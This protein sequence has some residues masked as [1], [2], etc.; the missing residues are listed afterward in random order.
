MSYLKEPD[1]EVIRLI[2]KEAL[3]AYMTDLV[4]RP[5]A[6]I[7]YGR[8]LD[9][10]GYVAFDCF[11]PREAELKG[12]ALLKDWFKETKNDYLNYHRAMEVAGFKHNR[13]G[14]AP[15]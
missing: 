15:T 11:D 6:L 5:V 8:Y 14:L 4:R 12:R 3:S 13:Q 2:H 7:G 9:Y 1:S 10:L